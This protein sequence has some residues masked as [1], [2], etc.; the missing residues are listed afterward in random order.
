MWFKGEEIQ[1]LNFFK[2]LLKSEK[3]CIYFTWFK[4]EKKLE[5]YIYFKYMKWSLPMKMIYYPT[6]LSDY[7]VKRNS[8]ILI[9][10]GN[11]KKGNKSIH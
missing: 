4:G 5:G 11:N 9:Q 6:L 1:R 8:K 3:I 7:K 10:H 2:K